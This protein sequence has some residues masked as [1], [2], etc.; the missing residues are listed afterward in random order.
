MFKTEIKN[1][2]FFTSIKMAKSRKISR[3]GSRKVSKSREARKVSRKISHSLGARK[4]SR[5][6]SRKTQALSRRMISM[7][8]RLAQVEN[9]CRSYV[10]SR[11]GPVNPNCQWR[12]RSG[13]VR[14]KG[15]A[16]K[17]VVFEGPGME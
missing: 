15:T 13:C 14:R 11:C 8:R 3:K 1:F 16:T 6:G 2:F 7:K 17:G 4:G 12:K 10:K 9:P 5:K